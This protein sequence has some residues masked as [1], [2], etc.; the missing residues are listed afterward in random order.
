MDLYST[1]VVDFS[2]FKWTCPW[3]GQFGYNTWSGK[4]Y[5]VLYMV[6][7]VK[8]TFVFFSVGSI[9]LS[10]LS[11]FNKCPVKALPCSNNELSL[12][13]HDF[14]MVENMETNR[15]A[16][17]ACLPAQRQANPSP[18]VVFLLFVSKTNHNIRLTQKKN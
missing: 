11:L 15:R 3:I 10:L 16:V 5:L 9:D 14:D 12:T 13:R 4:K 2:Y 1:I 8:S 17:V 7:M 6:L 18:S